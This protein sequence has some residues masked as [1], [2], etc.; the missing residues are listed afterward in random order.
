MKS[1]YFTD[2]YI[3][4]RS[5]NLEKKYNSANKRGKTNEKKT[6]ITLE[7]IVSLAKHFKS[8]LCLWP[9]LAKSIIFFLTYQTNSRIW[10]T[11]DHFWFK[12]YEVDK[13]I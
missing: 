12:T 8:C 2:V 7:E 9:V 11:N 10:I 6:L 1:I 3:R 13:M 5:R 4:P